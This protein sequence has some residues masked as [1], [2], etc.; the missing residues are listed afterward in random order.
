MA[1]RP[2]PPAPFRP[3]SRRTLPNPLNGTPAAK[4]R[5]GRPGSQVRDI[6][7]EYPPKL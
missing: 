6:L 2:V 3:E 5:A 7:A 4:F 1:R